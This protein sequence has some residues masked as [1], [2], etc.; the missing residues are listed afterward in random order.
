MGQERYNITT[1]NRASTIHI[2]TTASRSIAVT[3][4]TSWLGE[5]FATCRVGGRRDAQ[6]PA[7]HSVS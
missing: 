1:S 3:W 2:N 4:H 6:D 5:E 7:G